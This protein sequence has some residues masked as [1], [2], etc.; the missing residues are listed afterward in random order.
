MLFTDWYQFD[1]AYGIELDTQPT[2]KQL[3]IA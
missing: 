2:Y 1:R 3:P